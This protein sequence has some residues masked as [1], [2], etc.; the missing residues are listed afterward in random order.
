MRIEQEM[1]QVTVVQSNVSG[2]SFTDVMAEDLKFKNCNVA[3]IS[4]NDV[5]M[6]AACIVDA[7]LSELVIDGAQWGGAELR[8]IGY[9]NSDDP[10]V[11]KHPN[12]VK[13][14]GCDL[15]HGTL[16]DCNLSNANL[17]NCDITGLTI[18]GVRIDE[19][20]KKVQSGN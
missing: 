12:A 17:V 3:R 5:N 2:S 18:N 14:T 7:N 6:T 8:Y 10:A 15:S 13:M 19:L 1:K 16:A 4:F 11:Q 20:L 9:S